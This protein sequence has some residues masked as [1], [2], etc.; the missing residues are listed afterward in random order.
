MAAAILNGETER[1]TQADVARHE[2]GHV[3][4][5]ALL[6]GGTRSSWVRYCQGAWIGMTVPRD[7]P[8]WHV[9]KIGGLQM[10]TPQGCIARTVFCW[11]GPVAERQHGRG[12]GALN[13]ANDMA[14]M[15]Q[16]C[17]ALR[18]GITMAMFPNAQPEDH[19]D[20]E[21][22]QHAGKVIT[23]RLHGWTV[24]ALG[25][26]LERVEATAAKL[27]TH[28]RLIGRQLDWIMRGLT[29]ISPSDLFDHLRQGLAVG[30][31]PPNIPP[32]YLEGMQ[33]SAFGSGAE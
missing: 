5:S 13:L 26:E 24:A 21:S 27:V 3:M 6:G 32:A 15:V 9:P 33:A 2:A 22:I 20:Y 16:G 25:R 14:E 4:G 7:V 23:D 17:E 18:V 12:G 28:G 19:D 10:L 11:S 31:L 30:P 1:P 29:P 8:A